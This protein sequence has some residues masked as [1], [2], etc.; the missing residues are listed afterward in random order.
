MVHCF[1]VGCNTRNDKESGTVRSFAVTKKRY[2]EWKNIFPEKTL[3]LGSRICWKHF[4]EED[5][6]TSSSIHALDYVLRQRWG[7]KAGAIP[8][9]NLCEFYY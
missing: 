5:M 7:L 1:V 4:S 2:D 3:K 6:V 8:K 9:S